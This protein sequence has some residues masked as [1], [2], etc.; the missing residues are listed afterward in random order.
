MDQKY[1]IFINN[2]VVFLTTNPANVNEILED[3][4]QFIFQPFK[5]KAEMHHWIEVLMGDVNSSNIIFYH[6]DV[7][8]ML[9][10]LKGFFKVIEAAGG[11]VQNANGEF[12]LIFRK[13]FWD[14]PKGKVEK[15][16]TIPEAAVREVKEETGIKNIVL[17]EPVHFN[18]LNNACTYHTYMHKDKP[19][20]K[21]SYWYHMQSDSID[22]VPQLEE[23]IEAAIWVKKEEL[24]GYFAKMYPSIKDVL[25][26]SL[27]A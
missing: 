10:V 12:L 26:D 1:K 16:E 24:A 18:G 19:V 20:L 7:A 11:L 13:G 23:E 2:K 25:L 3:E 14:L 5:G 27:L 21:A 9:E 4:R 17:L 8:E 22:L 6:D 15:K